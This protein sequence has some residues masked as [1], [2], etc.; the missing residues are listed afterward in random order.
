MMTI[1]L[2]TIISDAT[3]VE[4]APPGHTEDGGPEACRSPNKT[5][6]QTQ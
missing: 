3:D 4:H 2:H 1:V 5:W 6:N